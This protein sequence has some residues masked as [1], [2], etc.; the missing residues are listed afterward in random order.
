[1]VMMWAIDH[2]AKQTSEEQKL[3]G[4]FRNHRAE[5]FLAPVIFGGALLLWEGLV[6][7]QQY[8]AFILPSPGLVAR[9]LIVVI[10]DGSL[11][12]HAQI[13]LWEILA[14]LG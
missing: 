4:W 13:T 1:M 9:K 12:Y 2:K 10:A 5:I 14:G 6:R 11:W 7:W 8:P 3:P